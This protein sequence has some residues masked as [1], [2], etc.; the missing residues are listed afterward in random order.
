MNIFAV[1]IDPREAARALGDQHV[2]KM[3]LESVQMLYTCWHLCATSGDDWQGA[4]EEGLAAHPIMV[5][6]RIESPKVYKMTH[7]QHPCAVWVRQD[8][9]NYEW[10]V[11]HADELCLE[12]RR[13]WPKNAPHLCEAHL[14]VLAKPPSSLPRGEAITP[15]A[16]AMPEDLKPKSN[17]RTFD[18]CTEAYRAYYKREK[19]MRWTNASPP[20]WYVM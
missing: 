7:Q 9:L 5:Q 13:R 10:L 14:A 20:E 15:F 4:M 12:K 2:V 3:I 11:A 6:R 8:A 19:K 18:E 17:K 1:A 16:V